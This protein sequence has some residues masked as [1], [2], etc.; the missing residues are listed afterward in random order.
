MFGAIEIN[1][2]K[3]L[4]QFSRLLW[5]RK[6]SHRIHKVDDRQVLAVP[7]QEMIPEVIAL[8]QQWENGDVAPEADDSTDFASYFSASDVLLRFL[9]AFLKSPVTIF[10]I[11]VCVVLAYLA[12]LNEMG[13]LAQ[14]MLYPDFSYGT[15]FIN[16][17]Q[18]IDNFT[19]GQFFK[20]LSPILL[21]AGLL[22]LA[23]NM[24]WMWEFGKRI[25][26]VQ[27]SLSMFLN[28][29]LLGVFSNTVQYI[30]G[31]SIYFGGMS[32]VVYGLFGYIVMWQVFDPA[33]KLSLP[34]NLV[35]FLLITLFIVSA[36]GF[37]N[38][39]DAAHIGGFVTGLL[40]GAITAILSRLKRSTGGGA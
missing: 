14:A 23:F 35:F 19:F 3:N 39:A 12:P 10:F 2:Q 24:L 15:S 31:G 40:L 34:W 5:Q 6:I 33:K 32:G 4:D 8:Y 18:V 38:I 26:A 29:V 28:V 20:M 16:V 21:H 22:H 9:Q 27:S 17:S 13:G 7:K 36:L 1:G 25:E 37:D 11:L 30:Y